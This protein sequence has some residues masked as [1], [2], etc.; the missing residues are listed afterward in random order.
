M[1]FHAMSCKPIV[2]GLLLGLQELGLR[3]QG[4]HV[5]RC[6]SE[7]KGVFGGKLSGPGVFRSYFL[8]NTINP[9]GPKVTL[10]SPQAPQPRVFLW[11]VRL[12]TREEPL[13]SET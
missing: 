12:P 2:S 11:A 4:S 6:T 1:S 8:G 3:S 5:G 10:R 9:K 13:G 7:L